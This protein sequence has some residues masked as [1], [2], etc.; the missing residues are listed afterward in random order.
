MVSRD[1]AVRE[2]AESE[3]P[4]MFGTMAVILSIILL[5][6]VLTDRHDYRDP[7]VPVAV[8]LGMIVAAVWLVPRARAGG[9]LTG[10][11]A[12]GAVAIAIAA[13]VLT[14][15]DRRTQGVIGTADWSIIGTVWL[16]A[17]VALSRPAWMWVSGA[18]LIFAAHAVFVIQ[19]PDVTALTMARLAAAGYIMA[20]ILAVF[21]ALRPALRTNAA[22]AA[23]R[24]ALASRSAAERAA[25]AAVHDDRRARRAVLEL[26]ALPL[27][28][29]I[30]GGTLDPADRGV[31]ERCARHAATLRQALTDRVPNAGGLLAELD[32]ALRAARARGLRV[33]VQ[34]VGDPGNPVREVAGATVAA[35]EGVMSALPPHPVLLTILESGDDVELYVIFDRLLRTTPDV[36]ALGRQVPATARWH[37]TV[38]ID[39]SGAGC[40]EVRWRKVVSV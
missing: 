17:L 29:G 10:A 6:Q 11:Q 12:T 33:E 8:W 20:V 24:A 22:L 31:R 15:W 16:L 35:V 18:L 32:P 34:V 1:K 13:V 14:G 4:R 40:L 3:L 37:A 23:R 19:V 26:E 30:A 28:R 7:A 39:D 21:A 27:L 5:A 38:G 9:G 25:A 36:T 2:A